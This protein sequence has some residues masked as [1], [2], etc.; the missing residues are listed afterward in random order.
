M[1]MAVRSTAGWGSQL[2]IVLPLDATSATV[3]PQAD[4]LTR[5]ERDVLDLL[6]AGRHNRAISEQLTISEN[7]VKV[8]VA[9]VLRK[10]GTSSRAELAALVGAGR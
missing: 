3:L 9:N 4:G 5:R 1:W 7:I 10:T 2:D 8:H 6:V